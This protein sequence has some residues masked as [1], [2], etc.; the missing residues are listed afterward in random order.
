MNTYNNSYFS[1]MNHDGWY[2]CSVSYSRGLGSSTKSAARI[3][4]EN[5]NSNESHG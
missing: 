3:H 2:F 4:E 5:N 1:F